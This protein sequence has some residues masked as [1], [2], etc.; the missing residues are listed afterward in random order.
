GALDGEC[1]QFRL[2]R[3]GVEVVGAQGNGAQCV[4]AIV[5]AGQ[6][7][8]LGLGRERQQRMQQANAFRRVVRMRR[9]AQIHG[10]H[11]RLEAAHLRD[12][13]VVV[14]GDDGFVLI[15]SPTHLLLQRGLV[16]ND[17]QGFGFFVHAAR[18]M[19]TE[20]AA[21][22]RGSRTRTQVPSPMRLSTVRRPPMFWMYCALSYAPMPMPVG[23][24]VWNGWN[25]RSRTYSS[26][27]PAPLSRTSMIASS[28]SL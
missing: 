16:L 9:Q 26:L 2:E 25:S 17:Q 11:R 24:V 7:D 27:M 5:L 10:D 22:G 18:L 3:L 20:I 13:A 23:L 6:H 15:E 4:F 21:V 28:L 19:G 8:D 12:G 14:V 1:E